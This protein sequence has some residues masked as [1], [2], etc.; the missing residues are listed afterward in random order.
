MQHLRLSCSCG[1]VA[2]RQVPCGTHG[3]Q[4]H[5][6]NSAALP[7]L[8]QP[9]TTPLRLRLRTFQE[10]VR[11]TSLQA[12]ASLVGV[13]ACVAGEAGVSHSVSPPPNAHSGPLTLLRALFLPDGG[14]L[15]KHFRVATRPDLVEQWWAFPSR[16]LPQDQK[17]TRGT[18]CR[19]STCMCTSERASE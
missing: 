6:S 3:T 1:D 17:M 14:L 15:V 2:A 18:A 13:D 9:T 8:A 19:V 16:S 7:P 4:S 12:T 10:P 5:L 11:F